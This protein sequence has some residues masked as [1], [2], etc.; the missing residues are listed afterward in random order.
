G[1]DEQHSNRRAHRDHTK[2]LVRNRTQNRVV[3]REVPDRSNVLRCLQGVGFFKVGLLEEVTTHFREEEHNRAEHEQEDH[4]ADNVFYGVGGMERNA[5]RRSTFGILGFLDV[6]AVR[7]VRTHFVQ[8]QDMQ[9]DQAQ[10]D[11]RQRNH[12][13]R[14]EAVQRNAGYQVVATDPL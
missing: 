3:R 5:V 8:R 11:D 9:H 7:V 4:Y 1:Q 10:Q 12:V 6:D 2:Q 14:E 13:Q